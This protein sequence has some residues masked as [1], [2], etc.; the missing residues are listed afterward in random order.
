MVSI[1]HF[2]ATASLSLCLTTLFTACS[3]QQFSVNTST[4]PFEK[5]GRTW[6]ERTEKCGSDGWKLEEKR[7][8]DIHLLGIN[9]KKSNTQK[10]AEELNA[11]SYTIETKSNIIVEILTCGMVDYK[12][13]KVIK[14][15]N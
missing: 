7:D 4:K 11:Q 5:G 2:V 8:S 15:A 3:V 12:I 9:I 10:M 13:V 1:K 14:R 6:G